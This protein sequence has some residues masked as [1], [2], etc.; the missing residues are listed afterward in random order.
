MIPVLAGISGPPFA[1]R[2]NDIHH[3][4]RGYEVQYF[5]SFLRSSDQITHEVPHGFPDYYFLLCRIHA[6]AM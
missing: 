4:A 5:P 6:V 3:L 2:I 1:C